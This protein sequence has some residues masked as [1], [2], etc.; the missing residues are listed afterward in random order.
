MY[1]GTIDVFTEWRTFGNDGKALF[2]QPSPVSD[3]GNPPIRNGTE[4]YYKLGRRMRDTQNESDNKV[5]I[6]PFIFVLYLSQ[7]Y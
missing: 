5:S 7:Y 3:A 2:K 4:I 6:R 1:Y